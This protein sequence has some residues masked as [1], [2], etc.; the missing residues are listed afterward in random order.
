MPFN[1]QSELEN[2]LHILIRLIIYCYDI[3]TA[4]NKT[5]APAPFAASLRVD[6]FIAIIP[7][8]IFYDELKL[9]RIT[10]RIYISF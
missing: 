1:S 2:G 10:T 6:E 9:L 5:M 7:G 8:L 4:G 3:L